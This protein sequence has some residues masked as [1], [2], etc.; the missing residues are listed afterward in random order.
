MSPRAEPGP[1]DV[2]PEEKPPYNPRLVLLVAILLPGVGHL[3]NNQATRA[4]LFVTSIASLGWISYHL[5][6]P[7]HSFLGRYAGG[8]FVYAISILDAYKTAKLRWEIWWD[9]QRRADAES[10]GNNASPPN[11]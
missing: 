6:T 3:M 7:E 10:V 2:K 9:R 1:T 8:L 4:F 11:G 5:T